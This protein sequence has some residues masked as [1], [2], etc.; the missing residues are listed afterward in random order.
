MKQA[1]IA[2][3]MVAI[4]CVLTCILGYLH[5]A[6][7]ARIKQEQEIQRSKDALKKS[8]TLEKEWGKGLGKAIEDSKLP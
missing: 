8:P 4:L 2:K 3:I 1:L 5:R 7:Q 6:E